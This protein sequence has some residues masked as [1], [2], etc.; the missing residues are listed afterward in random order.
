MPH[1][2]ITLIT[3]CM[4]SGKTTELLRRVDAVDSRRT[5]VF[6]H[7]IDTRYSANAV[8][9]HG[10]LSYPAVVVDSAS[11][12]SDQIAS[13]ALLVGVDEAH[14]LD[15]PIIESVANLRQRGVN[16]VLTALNYDSWGN[17]FSVIRHLEKIADARI[18]LTA[19]CASCGQQADR[20]Q[21]TT[22]IVDGNMIGGA[23]SYEP[24]CVGCWEAPP[25]VPR[26]LPSTTKCEDRAGQEH[27][28][29]CTK[30]G[31]P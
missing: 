22:P 20:T 5:I 16:V 1:G 28:T 9:T 25:D 3:G 13:D 31:F 11:A 10:G 2:V 8:V 21:R 27:A 29:R 23:E 6:K 7:I 4:F 15:D 14:F 26:A 30:T 24:R 12:M 18:H 19:T 17:P